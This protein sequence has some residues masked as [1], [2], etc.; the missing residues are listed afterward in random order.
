[1][2]PSKTWWKLSRTKWGLLE[3]I[4]NG[5]GTSLTYGA[6]LEEGEE[7]VEDVLDEAHR[8]GVA[9]GGGGHHFVGQPVPVGAGTVHQNAQRKTAPR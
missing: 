9:F 8:G 6:G 3:S 2:K 5:G 7:L 1:M 4:E